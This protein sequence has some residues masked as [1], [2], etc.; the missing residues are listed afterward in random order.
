MPSLE[1]LALTDAEDPPVLGRAMRTLD[2]FA[3]TSGLISFPAKVWDMLLRSLYLWCPRNPPPTLHRLSTMPQVTWSPLPPHA[4]VSLQPGTPR[5][6]LQRTEDSANLPEALCWQLPEAT[7][8]SALPVSWLLFQ[9]SLL[10]AP[11]KLCPR[12]SPVFYFLLQK[13]HS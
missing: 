3:N 4:C 6:A 5:C 10:S 13:F 7:S 12:T 9:H 1:Y 11:P 8:F 2:T